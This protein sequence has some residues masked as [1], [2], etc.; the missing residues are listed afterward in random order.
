M[1]S[2]DEKKIKRYTTKKCYE[3]FTHVRLDAEVCPSC[4]S[5]LGKINAI[6]LAEKPTNWTAY[7]ICLV[8]WVGLAVFFW[9]SLAGG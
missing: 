4:K 8:V 9:K 5:K 2:D 3:C 7:I 6:G 1:G